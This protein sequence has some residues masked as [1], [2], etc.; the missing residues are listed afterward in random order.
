MGLLPSS[1]KII[2]SALQLPE[3]NSHSPQIPKT[4]GDANIQ[5]QFVVAA[6]IVCQDNFGPCFAMQFLMSFPTLQL[7]FWGAVGWS[8]VGDCGIPGHAHL[9]EVHMLYL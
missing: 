9:F 8:V 2:T 6:A 4:P 1:P 5:E 7:S 3:I